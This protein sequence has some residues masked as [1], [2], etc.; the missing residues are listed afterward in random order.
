MSTL[1]CRGILIVGLRPLGE[2]PE[3]SLIIS[4]KKKAF[5]PSGATTFSEA[6]Y[7]AFHMLPKETIQEMHHFRQFISFI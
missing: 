6:Q 4:G 1:E 3:A 2:V 7:T 5:M